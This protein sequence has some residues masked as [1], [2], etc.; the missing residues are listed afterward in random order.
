MRF[1]SVS[2]S[3]PKYVQN[4]GH[5][6]IEND[7]FDMIN[8]GPYCANLHF[9]FFHHIAVNR[10]LCVLFV[11]A[12]ATPSA[13]PRHLGRRIQFGP[14]RTVGIIWHDRI[15]PIRCWNS[16]KRHHSKWSTQTAT[17]ELRMRK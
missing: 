6:T 16:D 14:Q 4:A 7:L 3:S 12:N 9:P 1:S 17:L 15:T 13:R 2:L 11:F 8:M 5:R 10:F